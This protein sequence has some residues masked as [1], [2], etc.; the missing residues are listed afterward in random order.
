MAEDQGGQR[1]PQMAWLKLFTAFKVALDPKKLLLAGGGILMMAIGWWLLSLIFYSAFASTR[2]AVADHVMTTTGQD[3]EEREV[4]FRKFKAA[5][6]S[7]NLM[8]ELAGPAPDSIKDAI[9][10]DAGD[11]AATYAEY[12][13]LEELKTRLDRFNALVSVT[14][15]DASHFEVNKERYTFKADKG[16]APPKEGIKVGQI[17]IVDAATGKVLLGSVTVTVDKDKIA[18][19]QKF[20]AGVESA[21]QIVAADPAKRELIKK[22]MAISEKSDDLIL[23]FGKLRTLPWAEYRGPNPVLYATGDVKVART[24]GMLEW[25]WS[26]QIPVVLE[27]LCKLMEPVKSFLK[28]SAGFR[29]KI[30]LLFVMLWTMLTWGLFG[31]AITRMAAVQVARQNEKVGM[32]EA[33]RFARGRLRSFFFAPILPLFFLAF[34]TF[35]LVLFGWFEGFTWV[36]GDLVTGLFWPMILI[37]GL[38][39][40]AILVGL[41]GWPLMHATISAEGS[42]SF[43]ALSRSYSYVYQAPWHYAW[44]ALVSVAYGAVLIFFVGFM[45][46]LFV[47]MAKWGVATAPFVPD[48]REPSYFFA[49]APTSFGWRDLLLKQSPP[50]HVQEIRRLVNSG[51][52]IPAYGFT[53][54]YKETITWNNR[55]GAYLVTFWLGLVFLLIVGFG[56]S[57][58]WTSATIIYLLLR[59]KVDDTEL[60]EVHLEEED[61]PFAPEPPPASAEPAKQTAAVTM[62][63]SPTLRKP[64][65]NSGSPPPSSPS[66]GAAPATS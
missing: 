4:G 62:V 3:D 28:P 20:I 17:K 42:D 18:E 21:A 37:G 50:S 46:S 35:L 12:K 48:S 31:G 11:L 8:H 66:D 33:F 7:W 13:A 24:K 60:D 53:P 15:G 56:Y 2:P 38:V 1:L 54:E 63:E 19:L 55:I 16:K 29:E 57:F 23:P 32:V 51:E 61:E 5:R 14:M 9:R 27:P 64:A 26:D 47:Y 43:D 58:F 39:M 45:G 49:Y 59:R 40:A 6:A 22:A 30:Y 34:I 44:Y 36:L 65:D 41:V 25:L 52:I 10:K